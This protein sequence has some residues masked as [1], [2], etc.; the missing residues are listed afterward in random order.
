MAMRVEGNIPA[1]GALPAEHTLWEKVKRAVKLLFLALKYA[2]R[3]F[4]ADLSTRSEVFENRVVTKTHNYTKFSELHLYLDEP[5]LSPMGKGACFGAVKLFIE[6]WLH[7]GDI[8][9]AASLFEGGMPIEAARYQHTYETRGN[10]RIDTAWEGF[11][12]NRFRG[13]E[14][15][16]GIIDA[17]PHLP[18]GAYHLHIPLEDDAAHALAFIIPEDGYAYILEPNSSVAYAPTRR[19]LQET[20]SRLFDYYCPDGSWPNDASLI[21]INTII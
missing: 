6:R 18:P 17:I 8:H 13:V 3:C 21:K 16:W 5:T 9:A 20:L 4:E 11:S 12:P 2:W 7:D 15:G 1:Q 14:G 19:A 10:Y